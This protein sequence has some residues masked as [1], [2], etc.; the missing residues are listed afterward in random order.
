M[1][2]G[3][4]APDDVVAIRR[5]H[6]YD[7]VA[8]VW[9]EKAPMPH[10]VSSA[11]GVRLNGQFYVLGGSTRFGRDYVQAYNPVS[12]TWVLKTPLPT[13]RSDLAAANFVNANGQQRI[14]AVGGRG[15]LAELGDRYLRS[16]DVYT[17]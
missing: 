1:A 2:G 7:P 15:G 16:N 11:A 12:N 6:V 3:D 4:T 9:S 14:V 10:G 5:L 8:N 17:P 13:W